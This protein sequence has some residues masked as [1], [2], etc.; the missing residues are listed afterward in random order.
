[1]QVLQ[2]AKP[3]KVET[4]VGELELDASLNRFAGVPA[5]SSSRS[6]A[7]CAGGLLLNSYVSFANQPLDDAIDQLGNFFRVHV[8]LRIR[9]LIELFVREK[10]HQR[11]HDRFA[12]R[13]ERLIAVVP[14]SRI[15]IVVAA[16]KQELRQS[17]E[18]LFDVDRL[19]ISAG[20]LGILVERH[21]LVY[22]ARPA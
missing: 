9:E 7:L 16:L 18:Q 6:P 10:L 15:R 22:L 12:Q 17:I 4:L 20:E 3:E 13:V 5:I 1:Q 19:P 8:A 2:R 11:L 14:I 21:A